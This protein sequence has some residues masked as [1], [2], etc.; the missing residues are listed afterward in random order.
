M[1]SY[2]Y[3]VGGVWEKN[4]QY[5]PYFSIS[6]EPEK[7]KQALEVN[8]NKSLNLRMRKNKKTKDTQPDYQLECSNVFV[9]PGTPKGDVVF[10]KA[11]EQRQEQGPT[12]FA[13]DEM[14]F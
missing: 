10:F 4:G 3:K 6:V 7:M 5:G 8:Q 2:N 9:T 1:K 12:Q 14:P 13:D 11:A